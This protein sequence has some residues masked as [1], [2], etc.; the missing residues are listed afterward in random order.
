MIAIVDTDALLGIANIKDKHHHKATTLAQKFE[1]IAIDIIILPTVLG[2]F[3][4]LATSRI[5]VD[6]TKKFVR[7]IM[8]Q[9]FIKVSIDEEFTNEAVN[10]YQKQTS[11]EE[12]LFDCYVMIAARKYHADCILSFDTGYSKNGFLLAGDF[13]NQKIS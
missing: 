13:A 4:L 6:Q 5:G 8:E 11:K 7:Y 12:S 2:E 3:S 10:L 9:P 1:K